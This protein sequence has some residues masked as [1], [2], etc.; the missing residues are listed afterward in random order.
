M[1]TVKLARVECG[2][3]YESHQMR[4][5][6]KLG[7]QAFGDLAPVDGQIVRNAPI[8]R[9]RREVGAALQLTFQPAGNSRSNR[10]DAYVNDP[11]CMV[12]SADRSDVCPVVARF[13]T[14]VHELKQPAKI[15]PGNWPFRNAHEF[16]HTRGEFDAARGNQ[17]CPRV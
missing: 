7:L 17:N 16:A 10:A 13:R 8:E 11:Q 12:V 5:T 15:C 4:C 2:G 6:A 14:K 3:A 1:V 9:D